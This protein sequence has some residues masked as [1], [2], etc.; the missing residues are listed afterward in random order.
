VAT[1]LGTVCIEELLWDR[2][3]NQVSSQQKE[4]SRVL[5]RHAQEKV[6]FVVQ[7]VE[8]IMAEN[9]SIAR[10]PRPKASPN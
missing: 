9:R 7:P 4:V 2:N 8:N 3:F 5:D 10:H 6:G 1:G